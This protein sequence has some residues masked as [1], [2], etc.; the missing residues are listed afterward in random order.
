MDNY[1]REDF[2]IASKV[3]SEVGDGPN[4]RGLRRKHI[5]DQIDR[6]LGRLGT[7]YLDLYYIH[8]WDED[9]QIRETL[10]TLHD[11][12]RDGKVNYLGASMMA[13]WRLVK[14]FW[15]SDVQDS[16]SSR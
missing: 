8:R 13:T 14:A 1:D 9:T 7:D 6:T 10:A 16:S 4:D 15:T 11:L 2:V 5:R 3:Y 12:V